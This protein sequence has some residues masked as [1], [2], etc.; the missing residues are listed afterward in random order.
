MN[1]VELYESTRGVWAKIPDDKELKYAFATY[2]GIVKE[3]YEI[4]G[5][6]PA[7]SQ[8]YFFR[9]LDDIKLEKRKEFYGKIAVEAIRKLYIGKVIEMPKSFGTPFVKVG[10]N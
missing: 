3:V 10:L 2:N 7:G 4:N 9:T 8:E 1:S 6:L 5:W